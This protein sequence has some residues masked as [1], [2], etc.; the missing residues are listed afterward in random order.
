MTVNP[1]YAYTR[2]HAVEDGFQIDVSTTGAKAGIT[3]RVFAIA[4]QSDS[5]C[6]IDFNEPF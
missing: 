2:S 1:I 5:E 4:A 3:F 6:G